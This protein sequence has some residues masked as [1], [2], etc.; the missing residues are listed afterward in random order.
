MRS[1]Q[2]PVTSRIPHPLNAAQ[3]RRASQ[4]MQQQCW[5]WGC[6]IRHHD[7]NMLLEYGFVR[8]RPENR[9]A[10][11]SLYIHTT[12]RHTVMLWGFGLYMGDVAHG[13]VFIF[14]HIFHPVA[15][16]H[17]TVPVFTPEALI[18]IACAPMAIHQHYATKA[19]SWIV[20]YEAWVVHRMGMEYRHQ[21]IATWP[22]KSYQTEY[23]T[24]IAHWQQYTH[25]VDLPRDIDPPSSHK[26]QS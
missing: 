10:G 6:D 24:F 21:S 13:G 14:R 25:I 1:S 20:E 5:L 26:E 22:K 8:Y 7:G 18:G 11:S 12:A 2:F 16:A 3:Q 17:P 23:T 4:H 9:L 15:I 19:L